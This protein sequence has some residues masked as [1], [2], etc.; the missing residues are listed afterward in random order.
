MKDFEIEDARMKMQNRQNSNKQI[1]QNLTRS[2]NGFHIRISV[3]RVAFKV[4][5]LP[6]VLWR[7]VAQIK[8]SFSSIGDSSSLSGV[9]LEE[10]K[11][12]KFQILKILQWQRKEML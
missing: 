12:M 10:Q 6:D 3:W 4:P 9:H 7:K 8:D 5:S 11:L 1:W 2:R